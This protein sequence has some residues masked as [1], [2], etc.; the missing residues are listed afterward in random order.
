MSALRCR[1]RGASLDGIRSDGCFLAGVSQ[2]TPYSSRAPH[3]NCR[4]AAPSSFPRIPQTR[5]AFFGRALVLFVCLASV[6]F[7]SQD[8]FAQIDRILAPLPNGTVVA[9]Q[10]AMLVSSLRDDAGDAAEKTAGKPAAQWLKADDLL[11]CLE[12][13]LGGYYSLKGDFKLALARPWQPVKLPDADFKVV[14]DDYPG[15]GV[16]GSFFIRCKAVSGGETVG[17][18]QLALRGQL[19]QEVW[20]ASSRL[21]RGQA[22]DRS[23]LAA[24]KVDVL[25]DKQAFL[26]VD[27]DP[28]LYDMAQSVPAGR[29]L[30]KRD[31]NE[32]P[33]I[34]KGQVVEVIAKQGLLNVRMKA[35]ALED[36]VMNALIKMRNLDS[37][38]DFN[39][40]II[41]ENQVQVHF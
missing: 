2:R 36:G 6:Y 14:I 20:G 23:L 22:L 30:T 17:G 3:G 25:R 11:R 31:V 35:L 12:K 9:R 39:A 24:Q 33:L 37:R 27:A 15:E 21:D 19:W 18:W 4:C 8:A 41:N 34:H 7:Q 38:K 13:Q 26:P 10:E 32:R 16:S 40:Q 28:A 29:P 1:I 5:S